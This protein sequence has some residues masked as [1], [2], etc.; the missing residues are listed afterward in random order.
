MNNLYLLFLMIA[1]VWVIC[2][3]AGIRLKFNLLPALHP[4]EKILF[5]KKWVG[6][7][8]G[9]SHP[10]YRC[11]FSLPPILDQGFYVTDRRVL[12][13]FY[14]FRILAQEFDE[15]F[16]GKEKESKDTEFI[17]EI[18][19]GRHWLCGSY[20]EIVSENSTQ[21]WFRS[22]RLRIRIYMRN[23]EPVCRT[24]TEAMGSNQ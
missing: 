7:C 15:W 4:G 24:I 14:I 19:V 23:P 16:E 20:L 17:K 10:S 1:L 11:S 2:R 22:K 21:Q 6:F 5:V 18:K 3:L 12:H 13:V 8:T 9:L